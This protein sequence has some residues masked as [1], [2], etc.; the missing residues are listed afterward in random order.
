MHHVLFDCLQIA[1]QS[2]RD[3][4]NKFHIEYFSMRIFAFYYSSNQLGD[5]FR[6]LL[7]ANKKSHEKFIIY[8]SVLIVYCYPNNAFKPIRF[9]RC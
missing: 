6:V 5:V 1:I 8:F 2:N 7:F 3:K 9:S 4:M